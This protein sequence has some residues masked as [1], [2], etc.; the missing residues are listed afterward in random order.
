M[1]GCNRAAHCVIWHCHSGV[2]RP[3]NIIFELLN[4]KLL[5]KINFQLDF[6]W[7]VAFKNDLKQSLRAWKLENYECIVLLIG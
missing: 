4:E 3:G 7:K 1:G 2:K 5:S 6:A